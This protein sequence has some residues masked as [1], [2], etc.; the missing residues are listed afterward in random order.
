MTSIEQQ[1][2]THGV[3]IIGLEKI[4]LV[5]SERDLCIIWGLWETHEGA[6]GISDGCA[7]R[8]SHVIIEKISA[9]Q[10]TR[11]PHP[12]LLSSVSTQLFPED[13]PDGFF[14]PPPCQP[15]IRGRASSG[16]FGV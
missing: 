7:V 2:S 12:N 16:S 6:G 3:L 11:D 13:G 9:H 10:R 4:P 5:P 1:R 14:Y 8:M 15:I